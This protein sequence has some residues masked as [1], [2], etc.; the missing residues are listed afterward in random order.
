MP[1]I[2]EHYHTLAGARSEALHK[3]WE[4]AELTGLTA[5]PS[6]RL[7]DICF[8]LGYNS[9]VSCEQAM[10][11]NLDLEIVALEI[12]RGVVLK[13]TKQAAAY[14]QKIDW[15]QCLQQLL[16]QGFWSQENC[17]IRLMLGDA[18]H[19]IEQVGGDFGLVLA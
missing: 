13:A 18:R 19:T 14:S 15:Q 4:P 2:K 3:Y 11:H 8:G 17:S 16:A 5:G 7:L 9:L 1:K 10:E 6:L 12:D